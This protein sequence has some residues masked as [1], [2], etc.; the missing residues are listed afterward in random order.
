MA[1]LRTAV[2]D[3]GLQR[4]EI[5]KAL[6]LSSSTVGNWLN[7]SAL[8]KADVLIGLPYVLGVSA[9]WLLS[10]RGEPMPLKKSRPTKAVADGALV[11]LDAV[12]AEVS[13]LRLYFEGQRRDALR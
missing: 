10:G 8:P 9:D 5:A 7:H 6:G 11:A 3:S 1:R 13:R 12:Q 4:V 2:R